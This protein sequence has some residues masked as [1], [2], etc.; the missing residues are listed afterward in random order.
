MNVWKKMW[1]QRL[2]AVPTVVRAADP[3]RALAATSGARY[4]NTLRIGPQTSCAALALRKTQRTDVCP[5]QRP[6]Q[7]QSAWGLDA[8]ELPTTQSIPPQSPR[9]S[10]CGHNV[11]N[12]P[13][14]I[15]AVERPAQA[16][17]VLAIRSP[18]Y[19]RARRRIPT[20]TEPLPATASAPRP[21]FPR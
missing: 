3:S 6:R 19:S 21:P 10:G 20:L 5:T 7:Q 15:A 8:Q 2:S 18:R 16:C 12:P 17:R 13:P 9:T 1:G 14:L 11:S 4:G